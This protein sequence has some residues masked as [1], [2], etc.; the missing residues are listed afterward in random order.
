MPFNRSLGL[1][2][3]KHRATRITA[4]SMAGLALTGLGFVGGQMAPQIVE[5]YLPRAIT[6]IEEVSETTSSLYVHESSWP[7]AP[8]SSP[9]PTAAGLSGEVTPFTARE[10]GV[11][12]DP[13]KLIESGTAVPWG[14]ASLTVI[15]SSKN[16]SDIIMIQDV[17]AVIYDYKEPDPAWV[18]QSEPGACGGAY[19]RVFDLNLQKG[20]STVE[21]LGIQAGAGTQPSSIPT[22]SVESGAWTVSQ[23][24]ISEIT[25]VA[26]PTDGYYEYGIEI[27]YVINGQQ[28]VRSI[29]TPE[30]P[31][32][33][34]GGKMPKNSYIVD[35]YGNPR[36][37]RL[38][39][40]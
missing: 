31:Y 11:R 33:V 8:C 30:D 15:L 5:R 36:M 39:G 32:R 25:F 28:H 26:E 22:E 37:G 23:N 2:M 12:P 38:M 14:R 20:A 40:L 18:V 3:A 6:G 29:G 24:D 13:I 17:R 1:Q 4:F 10:S 9:P 7:Y 16:V 34:I 19:R 35:M 21:D 27:E